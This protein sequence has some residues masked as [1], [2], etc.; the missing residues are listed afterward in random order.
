MKN[1]TCIIGSLVF[2]IEIPDAFSLKEKRRVLNSLKTKIKNKFNVSISEIGEKDI[3]NRSVLA[4]VTV[5]DSR[6][7]VDEILQK[8]VNFFENFAYI[9]ILSIR[10]EIL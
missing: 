1:N 3:W 2:E 6:N 4:V 5:S 9:N 7:F 10:E 8:V